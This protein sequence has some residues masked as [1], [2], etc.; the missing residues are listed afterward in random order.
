[1]ILASAA[2][3]EV[4]GEFH[5]F[6][7]FKK[8]GKVLNYFIAHRSRCIYMFIILIVSIQLKVEKLG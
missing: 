2:H 7:N 8:E 3:E 5:G 6:L 1:M 4:W